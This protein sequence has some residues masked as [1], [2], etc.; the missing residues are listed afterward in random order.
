M[1]LTTYVSG[2][3]P[4]YYKLLTGLN[5]H[6]DRPVLRFIFSLSATMLAYLAYGRARSNNDLESIVDEIPLFKLFYDAL[7]ADLHDVQK[8]TRIV[9]EIVASHEPFEKIYYIIR[10]RAVRKR[11]GAFFTERETARM[12][13]NIAAKAGVEGGVIRVLDPTVGGGTLLAAYIEALPDSSILSNLNLRGVDVDPAALLLAY[14]NI[15]YTLWKMDESIDV[16]SWMKRRLMLSWND[17]IHRYRVEGRLASVAS[18]DDLDTLFDVVIA[19]PPWVHVN[20]Y[21]RNR[22]RGYLLKTPR[23]LM[24]TLSEVYEGARFRVRWPEISKSQP[25]IALA[26]LYYMLRQFR[27]VATILVTGTILKSWN[28]AGFRLWLAENFGVNVVE[29]YCRDLEETTSWPVILEVTRKRGDTR[30]KLKTII[31]RKGVRAAWEVDVEEELVSPLTRPSPAGPWITPLASNNLLRDITE[32]V[33]GLKRIGELYQI[34]RGVNT[35][36]AEVFIF[37]DVR[38]AGGGLVRATS[39]SGRVVTLEPDLLHVFLRGASLTRSIKG[40]SYEYILLPHDT[41]TMS[42]LPE[43]VL[44]TDYPHTY[45]WLLSHRKLLEGRSRRPRPWFRVMDLSA[46]KMGG[47]RVAWRKHDVLLSFKAIPERVETPIG[48]RLVV[49]DGTLYYIKAGENEK[50]NLESLN[51]VVVKLLAWMTAKPKGGFPYREYYSWH[52]ALLPYDKDT[53]TLDEV[54]NRHKAEIDRIL[55]TLTTTTQQ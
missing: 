33:G 51:H 17:Y 47:V 55:K 14:A 54:Y 30:M 31:C 22:S 12:M 18:V 29:I 35:N 43:E 34:Y 9:G 38:V 49:P 39:I 26:F 32:A 7:G 19:N 41:K 11:L 13:A 36:A 2:K 53:T 42:P 23:S 6:D 37:K 5:L 8:A 52:I 1:V 25:P 40:G 24:Y 10:D 27:G 45:K 20:V 16:V 21:G 44:R 4:D 3:L 48:E 15:A 50:P 46:G 28:T